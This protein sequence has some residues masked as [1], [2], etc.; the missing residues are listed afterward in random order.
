M[1]AQPALDTFISDWVIK[2]ETRNYNLDGLVGHNE[3][4]NKK[5][6]FPGIT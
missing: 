1:W 2:K 5:K 6:D 3:T 4:E